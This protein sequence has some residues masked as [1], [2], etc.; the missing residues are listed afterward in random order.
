MFARGRANL[1]FGS[2]HLN[3]KLSEEAIRYIRGSDKLHRVLAAELSVSRQLIS[4]V[5]SGVGWEHVE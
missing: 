2:G 5:K 4:R 3:S 1:P